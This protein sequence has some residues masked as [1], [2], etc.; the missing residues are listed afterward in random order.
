LID[1][2][3]HDAGNVSE[4]EFVECYVLS[5]WAGST[6]L[7]GFLDILE[8][9]FLGEFFLE[10]LLMILFYLVEPYVVGSQELL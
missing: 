4:E 3:C 6:D 9:L 2:L 10:G 1:G 5:G 7:I 8:N